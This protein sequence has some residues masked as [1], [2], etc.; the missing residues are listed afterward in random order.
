VQSLVATRNKARVHRIKRNSLIAQLI[1]L[2][3][4]IEL[5]LFA[6]FTGLNLPTATAHNLKNSLVVRMQILANHLPT[7]LAEKVLGA[8]PRLREPTKEVRYS[9]YVPEVPTAIFVGYVL[10]WPL[11]MIASII[12]LGFGLIGPYFNFH[13]FSAG[14]GPEYYLQ[15]TF[16]Y[17]LGMVLATCVVSLLVAERRTSLNQSLSLLLGLF[18]VHFVGLTYMLALCL[19]FAIFDDSRV[20]PSW[21][22]WLFEQAR[23]LT[24]YSLP[25]DFLFG[26]IAV[27]LGYPVKWLATTLV[28]PD[29]GVKSSPAEEANLISV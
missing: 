15:P 3:M 10:A 12:F 5:F 8:Y 6:S 18:S 16:G 29:I 13:F 1:L 17:L 20:S 22:P 11:G 26:L 9:V 19:L 23:N 7:R 21:A 24:W 2:A 25:Y 28:A 14:G 27:G 4:A